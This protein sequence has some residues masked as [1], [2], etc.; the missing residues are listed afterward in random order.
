MTTGNQSFDN[1][2]AVGPYL[3]GF[4]GTRVWNGGDA[5]N[6]DRGRPVLHEAFQSSQLR[7][8]GRPYVIPAYYG[9]RPPSAKKEW[10]GYHSYTFGENQV[11]L[12]QK[13]GGTVSL[14]GDYSGWRYGS[15][16]NNPTQDE[17]NRLVD[18][19]R[20][21]MIG[22]FDPSVALAGLGQNLDLIAGSATRIAKMYTRLRRGDVPG[23]AKALTRN[24]TT[25]MR[26]HRSTKPINN[27]KDLADAQLGLS[28]GIIPL[29]SDVQGAAEAIAH[30]TAYPFE[31]QVRVSLKRP[32]QVLPIANTVVQSLDADDSYLRMCLIAKIKEEL[33]VPYQLGLYSLPSTLYEALPWSFVVD[34]F[35]PVSTYLRTRSFSANL[36]AE[37]LLTQYE[38]VEIVAIESFVPPINGVTFFSDEPFYARA[39]TV[40]RQLI[41]SLPVRLG[42][43]K[44]LADVPGWRRGINAVSL[45]TQRYYRLYK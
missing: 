4:H 12:L 40:E 39:H 28:Y 37:Y 42:S 20:N 32:I 2:T 45:L 14:R 7:A 44:N 16:S 36:S 1:R 3:H 34:W 25:K 11:I 10:H 33:S 22:E 27:Y 43:F 35:I 29:L 17:L 5:V 21:K 8:D 15:P 18:R 9:P 30:R 41:A 38:V 31:R 23:A 13:D 24:T 19:L 6:Y 26:K